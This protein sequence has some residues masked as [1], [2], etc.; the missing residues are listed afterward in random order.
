M[1]DPVFLSS[2]LLKKGGV[3]KALPRSSELL[4]KGGAVQSS[5][6]QF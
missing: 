4:K 1:R 6:A 2:E 3:C 5:A